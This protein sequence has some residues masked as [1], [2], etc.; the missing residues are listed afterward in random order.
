MH[1]RGHR[2]PGRWRALDRPVCRRRRA[3][4]ATAGRAGLPRGA[5]PHR[6]HQEDRRASRRAGLC[7]L[8]HGLSRR[9]QAARQPCRHEAAHCAPW[10]ADPTGIRA[11]ATAALD[12]LQGA[13]GGRPGAARRHRL[14][15]R[16]HHV[17]AS[18]AAAAATSRRS[19]ASIPASPPRGRRMPPTSRARCW[20]ASA[21]TI[22]SSRPSSA[23]L[24]E[25][26][27][28]RQAIDWRLQ[29]YGGAGHSFTNPAADSSR[30][31]KGFF[32]P[33]GDR[34]CGSWNAMIELFNETLKLVE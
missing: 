26:D 18:S 7:R 30:H 3:S 10:M 1:T 5:G 20:S 17:A 34:S 11:R 9:R 23:R 16:R 25:G 2:I 28:G 15:L 8:R 24:R 21:P 6:A 19:S 32:Y 27:E 12:V 13:E 4:P 31:D 22:R 14:L 29:L 33:R